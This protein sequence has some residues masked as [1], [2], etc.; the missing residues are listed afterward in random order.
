[1]LVAIFSHHV[2]LTQPKNFKK[3]MCREGG[4]ITPKTTSKLIRFSSLIKQKFGENI[5]GRGHWDEISYMRKLFA[6][7]SE[8]LCLT[9][10]PKNVMTKLRRENS[11]LDLDDYPTYVLMHYNGG[12]NKCRI[13]RLFSC[14]DDGIFSDDK[15]CVLLLKEKHFYNVWR[16]DILFNDVDTPEIGTKR[17]CGSAPHYK[18]LFCLRCMVSYSNDYLHVCSGRCHR[19]LDTNECHNSSGSFA[20][21]V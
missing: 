4:W 16:H 7:D 8:C 2:Y 5:S 9:E 1:M 6:N 20:E 3:I 10:T 13:E 15:P 12:Q 18:K 17:K 19:W 21:S 14:S 11:E